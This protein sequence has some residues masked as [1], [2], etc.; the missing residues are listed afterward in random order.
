M[1]R[2]AHF[3]RI[4]RDIVPEV[5]GKGDPDYE[6]QLWHIVTPQT[7]G[8]EHTWF[9]VICLPRGVS[10]AIHAHDYDEIYFLLEGEEAV[11]VAE[12]EYALQPW[13]V[14]YFP[15]GV[16]HQIRNIGK[17]DAFHIWLYAPMP[18]EVSKEALGACPRICC[19]EWR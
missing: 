2:K 3:F 4:F 6:R 7:C 12:K 5:W 15:A 16:K 11:K 8:S 18:K 1:E 17:K 14:M 13:D 19:S 10:G 9:G